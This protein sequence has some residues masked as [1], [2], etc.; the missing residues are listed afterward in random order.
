MATAKSLFYPDRGAVGQPE[1]EPTSRSAM[2]GRLADLAWLNGQNDP[3]ADRRRGG[4]FAK[5]WATA[6]TG[7]ASS[8]EDFYGVLPSLHWRNRV[9]KVVPVLA[10]AGLAGALF[11]AGLMPMLPP[12]INPENGPSKNTLRFESAQPSDSAKSKALAG[13]NEKFTSRWLGDTQKQSKTASM[14][15]NLSAPLGYGLESGATLLPPT[16]V[17]AAPSSQAKKIRTVRIRLDG[18]EKPAQPVEPDR[19][20]VL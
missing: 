20:V 18:P 9:G 19:E 7:E 6:Q 12:L 14:S 8:G 3:C 16:L 5:L 2:G 1:S 4:G 11:T 15:S 10:T 13:L 17:W